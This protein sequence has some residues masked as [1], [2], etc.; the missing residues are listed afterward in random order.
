MNQNCESYLQLSLEEET[1]LL[2]RLIICV[3]R[4][5]PAFRIANLLIKNCEEAGVFEK[6]DVQMDTDHK[7]M[8]DLANSI[9][10]FT[11]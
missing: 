7:A 5:E 10:N 2:G 8:S 4:C 1:K 3:Q 9:E 6:V 11:N